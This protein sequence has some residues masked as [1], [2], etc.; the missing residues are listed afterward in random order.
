MT[1][2]DQLALLKRQYK[3]LWAA[4][5]TIQPDLSKPYPD[6]PRWTPW[7]RFVAPRMEMMHA[8]LD[9]EEIGELAA[10]A[11]VQRKQGR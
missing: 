10:M 6:D 7:T 4:L 11:R 3:K 1:C 9:G 2:E 5:V 8:A